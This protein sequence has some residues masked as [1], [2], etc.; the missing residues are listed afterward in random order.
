MVGLYRVAM[1]WKCYSDNVMC[2]YPERS[3]ECRPWKH[4]GSKSWTLKKQ[5][6]NSIHAFEIWYRRK[7]LRMW[8]TVK[9]ANKWII[10][11]INSKFS[12][13]V[14]MTRLK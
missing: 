4:H 7:L 8:R 5:N 9:K 3:Q 6:K 1:L 12:L 14:Y 11:Q 2:L 13:E 10:E